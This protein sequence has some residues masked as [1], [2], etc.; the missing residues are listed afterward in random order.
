M[1]PEADT[2]LF[3]TGDRRCMPFPHVSAG[4]PGI[5]RGLALGGVSW[6]CHRPFNSHFPMMTRRWRLHFILKQGLALL[7]RSLEWGHRAVALLW[8]TVYYSRSLSFQD[9]IVFAALHSQNTTFCHLSIRHILGTDHLRKFCYPQPP[10]VSAT[11]S[12]IYNSF[13]GPTLT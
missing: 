3:V 10:N 2:E 12:T 4:A 1:Q 5:P 8:T 13:F 6:S 9:K 7:K 11:H